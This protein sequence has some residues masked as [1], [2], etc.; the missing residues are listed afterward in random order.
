[1]SDTTDSRKQFGKAAE[2][3]LTSQAHA[4]P[5]E[6]A[7]WIA[8]HRLAGAKVADI[9]TGAGHVAYA[10]APSCGEVV[11]VDITPEMLAIVERESAKRGLS[12]ISTMLAAA[13]ELPFEDGSLDG[14]ACRTAAHHFE[15][16][17]AFVRSAARCLKPGGWLW[18]EDTSSPEDDAVANELD[19]IERL[20]DPS[21]VWNYSLSAWRAM[22]QANNL[23]MGEPLQD[24][25]P[26]D[27]E[28]WMERMQVGLPDR[29]KLR[30][31]IQKGSAG[32]TALLSP[33]KDTDGVAWF[34]L[35]YIS[36]VAT[37]N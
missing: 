9:G 22:C 3:Y 26:I 18:I 6:L 20:R 37:R 8:S 2:A 34:D 27:L 28:Q 12:N 16:V 23:S 19:Q 25:K 5:D 14:I 17:E 30:V 21:H 1:M 33:R 13:E 24:C 10:L 11:A 29:E 4:K 31:M 15:D 36:F 35:P 32:I 7:D